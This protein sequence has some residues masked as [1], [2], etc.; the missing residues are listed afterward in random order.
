[1][2]RQY[3]LVSIL[4]SV[5][6]SMQ[7]TIKARSVQDNLDGTFTVLTRN[8]Q[9]LNINSILAVNGSDY[10]VSSIQNN[11]SVTLVGSP[12]LL[13]DFDIPAP[14]FIPDTPQGTNN[15]LILR[16]TDMSR[17]PLIW[18]LEN[19]PTNYTLDGSPSIAEARVRLF[20]LNPSQDD[21]WLESDHR[22]NCI[23]PMLNLT[24][25]FI[26]NLVDKVSGKIEAFTVTNR[27]RFGNTSGTAKILDEN[28]SGVELD[29]TIPIKKWAIN[30]K[31]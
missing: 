8:T 13:G 28:L 15:E 2:I 1:M 27:I 29:L 12:V 19:F 20:F 9:Y 24:D 11:E 10:F 23:E 26:T 5:I 31:N 25:E 22:I 14:L 17:H 3:N 4:R 7:I 18:L 21:S 30:C 16:S 6:S